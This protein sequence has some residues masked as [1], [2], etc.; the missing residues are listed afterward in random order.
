MG[1]H[2]WWSLKRLLR[3]IEDWSVVTVTG[4]DRMVE[5]FRIPRCFEENGERA[6]HLKICIVEALFRSDGKKE[7]SNA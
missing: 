4:K 7:E 2:G 3:R 6:T 1:Q 5:D